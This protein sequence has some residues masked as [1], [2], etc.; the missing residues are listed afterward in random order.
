MP[1]R[2]HHSVLGL[3]SGTLY[4]LTSGRR[5]P[6]CRFALTVV[7]LAGLRGVTAKPSLH[8]HLCMVGKL[9]KDET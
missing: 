8:G 9:P 7:T 2:N 1:D 5:R 4:K 3:V 6:V